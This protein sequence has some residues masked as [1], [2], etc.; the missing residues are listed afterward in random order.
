MKLQK[1]EFIWYRY[2]ITLLARYMV[3]CVESVKKLLQPTNWR[4][5]L[6]Q[7]WIKKSLMASRLLAFADYQVYFLQLFWIHFSIIST[8]YYILLVLH[9]GE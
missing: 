7:N 1:Y 3:N 5:L 9:V 2:I 4:Q 6:C 8:D